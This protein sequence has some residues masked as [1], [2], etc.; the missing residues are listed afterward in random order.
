MRN[1]HKREAKAYLALGALIAGGLW[2]IGKFIYTLI[3][4]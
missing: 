1:T 2:F 3:A 4:G